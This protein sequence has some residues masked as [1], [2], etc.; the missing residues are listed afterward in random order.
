MTAG[1]RPSVEREQAPARSVPAD[2]RLGSYHDQGIAPIEEPGKQRQRH[3]RC[4][5]NA[6]RFDAALLEQ[7]ELPAENEVLRF[8]E[9]PR[10]ERQHNEA[11]QVGK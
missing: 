4:R 6:P 7:R 1:E 5:V 3:P 2:Q 11:G 8:D 9:S 10:S